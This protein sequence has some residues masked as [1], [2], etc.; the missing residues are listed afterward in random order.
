M[1]YIFRAG[2]RQRSACQL[3]TRHP[4]RSPPHVN[5]EV[6]W[7]TCRLTFLPVHLRLPNVFQVPAVFL[8]SL[9]VCVLCVFWSMLPMVFI[10]HSIDQT[11]PPLNYAHTARHF[12]APPP[13]HAHTAIH[14]VAPSPSHAH[15]DFTF[16]YPPFGKPYIFYNFHFRHSTW[17]TEKEEIWK[18]Y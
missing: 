16:F 9:A 18:E 8:W 11:P 4:E 1:Y 14:F 10:Y 5:K 13:G 6:E 15:T 7:I 2:L 12:V 3:R 17:E